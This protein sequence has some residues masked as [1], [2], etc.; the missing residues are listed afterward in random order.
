MKKEFEESADNKSFLDDTDQSIEKA[1]MASTYRSHYSVYLQAVLLFLL[2]V[3]RPALD[4]PESVVTDVSEKDDNNQV[5]QGIDVSHYQGS[6]DWSNVAPLQDFIF[7]KASDGMTTIDPRFHENATA[8]HQYNTPVGAYHFFEP[9]DDPIAQA[10][11]YL[12][13]T[14]QYSLEFR[15]VLDIEISS[16]VDIDILS[17]NALTWLTYIENKTGC[18][19]IIYSNAPFWNKYLGDKFNRYDFWLADYNEIP[20]PPKSRTNWQLWQFTDKG[21]VP[22]MRKVVDQSVFKGNEKAFNQLLCRP[23]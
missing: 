15:P 12:K 10:Q 4:G 23:V 14:N 22:G 13:Q 9:N 19:P 6:I 17:K 16:G 1:H 21:R 8:L 20:E 7:L 11:H 5:Y 2:I 3:F 18:Q